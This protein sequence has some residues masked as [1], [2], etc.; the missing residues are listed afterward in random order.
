[1]RGVLADAWD[2][3][4]EQDRRHPRLGDTVGH[5]QPRVTERGPVDRLAATERACGVHEQVGV[6]GDAATLQSAASGAKTAVLPDPD[7]PVTMNSGASAAAS[8][9][10]PHSGQ[11]A[12]PPRGTMT[13]GLSQDWQ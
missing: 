11:T 10:D 1:V 7:A 12:C 6:E 9:M 3:W 2:E 5:R 13:I 4:A 8:S